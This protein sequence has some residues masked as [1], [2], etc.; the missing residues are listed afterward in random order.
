MQIFGKASADNKEPCN[1]TGPGPVLDNKVSANAA[2]SGPKT[3]EFQSGH[4]VLNNIVLYN[5][6]IQCDLVEK[7]I[8]MTQKVETADS[9]T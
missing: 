5:Y 9:A 8:P 2:T 4:N 1:F 7:N 3:S 6:G